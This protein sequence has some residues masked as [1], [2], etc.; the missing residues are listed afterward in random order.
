MPNWAEGNIRFRGNPKNIE[1][2]LKNELECVGTDRKTY[3][4][5]SRVPI[6]EWDDIDEITIKEPENSGLEYTFCNSLYIKGTR[7][8]FI[9]GVCGEYLPREEENYILCLDNFK[10]AWNVNPEPYIEKSAKYGIDIAI[11]V[12]ECGMEFRQRIEIINGKLVI[13]DVTEYKDWGWESDF[14]KMGG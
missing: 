6:I 14:P 2:F 7:R 13:D 3:D 11:V 5:I 12:Y 9:D 10:A 1:E 4:T 8:N